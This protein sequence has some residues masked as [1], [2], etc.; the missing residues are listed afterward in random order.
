MH[1]IYLIHEFHNLTWI[2]EINELFHDILIYWDAPVCIYIYILYMYMFNRRTI[3]IQV[4]NNLSKLWQTC[5]FKL[6]LWYLQS[7]WI[8]LEC[9]PQDVQGY[10]VIR[11][12]R[13]VGLY[14]AVA[15]WSV[16]LIIR[17]RDRNDVDR[18][19]HGSILSLHTLLALLTNPLEYFTEANTADWQKTKDY[20]RYEDPERTTNELC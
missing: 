3:H 9:I 13:L 14:S 17:Q 2:T 15:R 19:I 1:W 18:L 12:R 11:R 5:V 20:E 4:W 16:Q 6:L 7:Q 10:L 8:V